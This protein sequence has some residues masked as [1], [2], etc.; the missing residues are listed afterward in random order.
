MYI[1]PGAQILGDQ[2]DKFQEA[3]ARFEESKFGVR[4]G[5]VTA[6]YVTPFF[7]DGKDTCADLK[8]YM[9]KACKAQLRADTKHTCVTMLV[10]KTCVVG[11]CVHNKDTNSMLRP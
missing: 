4:K 2:R 7:L 6:F 10:S 9:L 5:L 8:R 1:K 11:L 3:M